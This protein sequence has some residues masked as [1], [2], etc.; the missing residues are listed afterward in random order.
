MTIVADITSKNMFINIE[1]Y[2]CGLLKTVIFAP[3]ILNTIFLP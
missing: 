2:F 1:K 3:V